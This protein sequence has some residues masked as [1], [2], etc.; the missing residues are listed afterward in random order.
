MRVVVLAMGVVLINWMANMSSGERERGDETQHR[1]DAQ[2]AATVNV[3]EFGSRVQVVGRMGR[4]LGSV[5][6]IQG[7]WRA[8]K[9]TPEHPVKPREPR[10][11]V[12]EVD[13][14]RLNEPVII[15]QEALKAFAGNIDMTHGEAEVWQ[16]R[17]IET[18]CMR[19]LPQRFYEEAGV[20]LP[21]EKSAFGFA[22]GFIYFHSRRIM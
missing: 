21:S 18:C 16:L 2:W 5:I 8:A 22:S 19:G 1:D 11:E 6:T 3:R 13:G 15:S 7:T 20:A 4:P 14:R 17:G 10:L 9:G 12:T